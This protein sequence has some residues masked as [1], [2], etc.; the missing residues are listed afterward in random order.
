MGAAKPPPPPAWNGAP[1]PSGATASLTQVL[2]FLP[3]RYIAS[4]TMDRNAVLT[5]SRRGGFL[6]VEY[7]SYTQEKV[8]SLPEVACGG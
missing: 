2:L 8:G 4:G 7:A 5:E 3:R 1:E 6:G